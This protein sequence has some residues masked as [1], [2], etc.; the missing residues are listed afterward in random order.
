VLFIL[1]Y[2]VAVRVV[3]F[4]AVYVAVT[5]ISPHAA[6]PTETVTLQPSGEVE[7]LTEPQVAAT[8]ISIPVQQ[9]ETVN[10]TLES[11]LTVLAPVREK[12]SQHSLQST[13]GC[14]VAEC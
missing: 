3:Q 7:L 6:A 5:V 11:G 9:G 10:T 12:L 13:S 14:L 2:F 8:V 1:I 4:S